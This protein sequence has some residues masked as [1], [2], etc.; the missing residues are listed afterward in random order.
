[1]KLEIVKEES[2]ES[3]QHAEESVVVAENLV[4]QGLDSQEEIVVATD[5]VNQAKALV[6]QLQDSEVK[7]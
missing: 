1:M 3:Y 6:E 4:N 5:A 7:R 2:D